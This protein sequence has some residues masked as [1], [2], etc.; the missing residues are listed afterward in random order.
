[1][2]AIFCDSLCK[3]GAPPRV[4]KTLDKEKKWSYAKLAFDKVLSFH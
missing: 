1:M 4:S 2:Q 3:K